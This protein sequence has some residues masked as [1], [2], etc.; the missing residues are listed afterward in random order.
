ML[1]T[2]V[3]RD[4]FPDVDI[5]CFGLVNQSLVGSSTSCVTS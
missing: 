2:T 1:V 3:M 4:N 5:V